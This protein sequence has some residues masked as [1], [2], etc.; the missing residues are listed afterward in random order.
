M[1][2]RRT[3]AHRFLVD[4]LHY[5]D[6]HQRVSPPHT[7]ELKELLRPDRTTAKGRVLPLRHGCPYDVF[8]A[9]PVAVPAQA[10]RRDGCYV[11]QYLAN[12]DQA[13]SP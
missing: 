13:L 4:G 8:D 2:L 7:A 6:Q 9:A 10:T 12:S 11:P 3:T 5:H 1:S